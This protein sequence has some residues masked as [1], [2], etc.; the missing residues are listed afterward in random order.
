MTPDSGIEAPQFPLGGGCDFHAV[1]QGLLPEFAT[2][3]FQGDRSLLFGF[4]ERVASV[5][6]IQPVRAGPAQVLK[7]M[8]ILNGDDGGQVLSTPGDNRALLRV[9]GAVYD[10]GEVLASFGD[11]QAIHNVRFVQAVRLRNQYGENFNAGQ[12]WVERPG[13]HCCQPAESG[14][15]DLRLTGF[16]ANL[17]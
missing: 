11:S 1:L 3:F 2:E 13:E 6:D 4:A 9:G 10:A 8:E 7:E 16:V 17:R 5:F 15:G 12:V 14:N